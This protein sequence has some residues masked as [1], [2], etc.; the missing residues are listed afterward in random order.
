PTRGGQVDCLVFFDRPYFDRHPRF[1][2]ALASAQTAVLEPGDAIFIPRMWWHHVR[3][4]EPFIVLVRYWWRS[5][6][7]VRSSPLPAL[8]Q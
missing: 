3:S 1:R 7:G 8:Q 6:P 4:L 5:V 2:D